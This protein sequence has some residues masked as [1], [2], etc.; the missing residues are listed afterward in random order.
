MAKKKT[1]KKKT[2]AKV[3]RLEKGRTVTVEN[4]KKD[5]T[6][7]TSYVGKSR[8]KKDKKT[9]K[10]TVKSTRTYKKPRKTTRKKVYRSV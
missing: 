2:P 6:G 5:A 1:V 3:K 9:G 7:K 10:V 8:I 4:R